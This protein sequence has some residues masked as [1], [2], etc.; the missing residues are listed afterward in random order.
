MSLARRNICTYVRTK[1]ADK[2]GH[3]QKC[4]KHGEDHDHK[5]SESEESMLGLSDR[6]IHYFDRSGTL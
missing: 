2:C 3:A 1:F 4:A 5:E 6:D